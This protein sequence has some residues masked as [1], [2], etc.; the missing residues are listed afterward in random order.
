[1]KKALL[2]CYGGGHVN[3]L[4]PIAKKL[5]KLGVKVEFFALTTAIDII[6]KTDWNYYTYADFFLNKD[7]IF[8]GKK[9]L[10]ELR[11]KKNNDKESIAYLGQN[12]IELKETL[13]IKKATDIYK[14][15]GRMSF[16]PLNSL[17]T[18][19]KNIN[20]DIVIT[21]NAPRSEKAA[22]NA[23]SVLGISSV[24]IGDLF[25]IRP[26]DWFKN[27]AFASTICV[28]NN[29]SK[30]KLISVGRKEESIKVTGN[31]AFD[32]YIKMSKTNNRVIDRKLGVLWA[33]QPEPKY[34]PETNLY[35]DTSLPIKIEKELL[36]LNEKHDF[37]KLFVRNHPN[38][39]TRSYPK[40]VLLCNKEK[41]LSVLN[42]I[43]VVVTA[44][45]I[46]GF[47]AVLLGKRLITINL[48]VLSPMLPYSEYG[49][50]NG[51]KQIGDLENALFKI[52]NEKNKLTKKPYNISDA[53]GN[54]CR[55][56]IKLLEC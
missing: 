49:Y 40:N 41:L 48:S 47:E 25:M 28:L 29:Q 13:G 31:P 20:P 2:V 21:T 53:T 26:L 32:S 56:V 15:Q 11:V 42:K 22:I 9:L 17:I 36:E 12:F 55:E 34:F 5:N 46:V 23:A 7:V 19:L 39:K 1:M 16:Y 3:M 44:T 38:E 18:V 50:S 52:H 10:S 33:S 37:I 6:S 54:V 51:L 24:A 27:N 30:N 14:N 43:D 8:Y 35:G 45:S 4:L